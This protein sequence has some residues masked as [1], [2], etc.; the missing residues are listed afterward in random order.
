MYSISCV[1]DFILHDISVTG[2]PVWPLNVAGE[3]SFMLVYR[4]ILGGT[5]RSR[6]EEARAE[7]TWGILLKSDQS[8]QTF[9]TFTVKKAA[10]CSSWCCCSV[11]GCLESGMSDQHHWDELCALIRCQCESLQAVWCSFA[12]FSG[13][14][15]RAARFVFNFFCAPSRCCLHLFSVSQLAFVL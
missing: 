2:R 8:N 14:S 3:L 7:L 1:W 5:C 13:F 6:G 15:D 4:V 10:V 9:Q 12:H 11:R